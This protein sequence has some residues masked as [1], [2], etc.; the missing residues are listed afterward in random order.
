MAI[1]K[2]RY[3]G[4]H[5]INSVVELVKSGVSCPPITCDCTMSVKP[6]NI[7]EVIVHGI[8]FDP[9]NSEALRSMDL[10]NLLESIPQLFDLLD[11]RDINYVLVGGIA[12]LAYVKGR[13]TQDID[14][15]EEIRTI[16]AD[17]TQRIERSRK[18]FEN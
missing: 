3:V 4:C 1:A 12:M 5:A 6:V 9:K 18:R 15:I 13:N 2:I 7:G 11:E 17:I 16:V 14:L 8:V 10:S